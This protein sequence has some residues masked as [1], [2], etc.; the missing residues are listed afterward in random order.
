[1]TRRLRAE[2]APGGFAKQA[3]LEAGRFGMDYPINRHR[4]RVGMSQMCH[5]LPSAPMVDQDRWDLEIDTA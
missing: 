2:Q 5:E 1:M 4:Y 3:L